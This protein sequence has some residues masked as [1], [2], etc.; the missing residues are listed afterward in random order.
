[1]TW[2]I[3]MPCHCHD[4]VVF[5]HILCRAETQ[6]DARTPLVVNAGET[7]TITPQLA[8]YTRT[9]TE[10]SRNYGNLTEATATQWNWLQLA[11]TAR[12]QAQPGETC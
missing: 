12:N 3:T 2:T 8:A 1:M 10:L 6:P 7:F 11:E 4:P 5:G 9:L